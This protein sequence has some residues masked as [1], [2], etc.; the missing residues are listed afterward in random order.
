LKTYEGMFLLDAGV[1]NDWEAIGAE[2][3]RIMR[4]AEAELLS[5]RKWDER[6]LAYPIRG[7]KRG[8]Y[9][10]TYFRAD[11]TRIVGLE[12]DTQ[13][14]ELVL[15]SLVL[16]AEDVSEEEIQ[17]EARAA[18]EQAAVLRAEPRKEP[19]EETVRAGAPQA[20][21]TEEGKEA[22][23]AGR[24]AGTEAAGD[25]EAQEVETGG[26]AGDTG[27]PSEPGEPS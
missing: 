22:P 3:R 26:E 6:R 8:C 10:L 11:P 13:L 24:A 14:S 21:E 17:R 16:K 25:A 5:C 19:E 7:R 2:I 9:V 1:A 18:A 23:R 20:A 15:R 27:G 4:R 12:R